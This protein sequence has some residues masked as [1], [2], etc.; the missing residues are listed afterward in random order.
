MQAQRG[1][2]VLALRVTHRQLVDVALTRVAAGS[3]LP[4]RG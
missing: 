1:N 3:G 2:P 4:L